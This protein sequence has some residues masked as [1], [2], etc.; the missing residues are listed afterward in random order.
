LAADRTSLCFSI[1]S[2]MTEF[3]IQLVDARLRISVRYSPQR[4]EP[5]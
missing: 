2:R 5:S 1:K 4:V 3:D